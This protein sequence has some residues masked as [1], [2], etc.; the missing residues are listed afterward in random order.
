MKLTIRDRSQR[1]Q[2]S[3][4]VAEVGWEGP[5]AQP[6]NR[7]DSTNAFATAKPKIL[8]RLPSFM[9]FLHLSETLTLMLQP[10]SQQEASHEQNIN[11]R[12][13]LCAKA[14]VRSCT[15]RH[16]RRRYLE[17][18][19]RLTGVLLGR[20]VICSSAMALAD[21]VHGERAVPGVH[22]TERR[23]P[24]ERGVTILGKEGTW[25]SRQPLYI[26]ACSGW[27]SPC[28]LQSNRRVTTAHRSHA[29]CQDASPVHSRHR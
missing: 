21:E 22:T 26:P 8:L 16:V 20:Y 4:A 17:I 6:L 10:F 1:P 18:H 15:Y 9:A 13:T 28:S 25:R 29:Q 24:F 5:E 27:P 12:H 3:V 2:L 19:R 7:S 23:L 14:R 11:I